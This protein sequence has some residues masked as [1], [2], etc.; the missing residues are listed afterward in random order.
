MYSYKHILMSSVVCCRY[1]EWSDSSGQHHVCCLLVV[2]NNPSVQ[3][4]LTESTQRHQRRRNEQS[5]WHRRLPWWST[6]VHR[7]GPLYLAC[8][9]GW[10]VVREVADDSVVALWVAVTDVTSTAGTVILAHLRQ[11]NT[12][13]SQLLRIVSTPRYMSQLYH[14]V[15]T[16]HGTFVVGHWGTPEGECHNAVSELF[17]FVNYQHVTQ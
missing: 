9:G 5:T 13:N 4:W 8:I 2:L 7:R 15:E 12:T 1:S 6:A 10:S 14:G 17:S 3:H 16:T 11:Y